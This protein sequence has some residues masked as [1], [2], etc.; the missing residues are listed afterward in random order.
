MNDVIIIGGGIA[1][2]SLTH[3]L[4]E[5]KINTILIEK[6]CIGG[7][8]KS[9]YFDKN[10]YCDLGPHILFL[11]KTNKK[12]VKNF[13]LQF[14]DLK[15]IKPYAK[16]YPTGKLTNPHDYPITQRNIQR[17]KNPSRMTL[18]VNKSPGEKTNSFEEYIINEIGQ[19]LYLKYFKNHTKKFWGYDPHLI[20]GNWYAKKI[21]FPKKETPFFGQLET[22]YPTC[23]Y[24][25]IIQNMVDDRSVI[26]DEVI[27]FVYKGNKILG[28]KTKKNGIINGKAFV[29]TINPSTFVDT[30]NLKLNY[31][32]IVIV[33]VLIELPPKTK[34]F[35]PYITWGYFPNHFSFTRIAEYSY[36]NPKTNNGRYLLTF[37]F[38]CFLKD[39]I[40]NKNDRWFR[41]YIESF[42]ED[43]KLSTKILQ[44]KIEKVEQAYPLPI[45]EEL[46]K[47]NIIKKQFNRYHNL[48]NLGRIGTYNYIWMKDIIIQAFEI[49]EK[50]VNR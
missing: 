30:L 8:L 28:V 33:A 35:E 24:S 39:S 4:K 16:T 15:I 45:F 46:E 6:H 38:P 23:K 18:N 9:I 22:Y 49:A 32:A 31:R 48:Y 3:L 27:G 47:Y 10:S 20:T 44:I 42:F 14:S 1:G 50:I 36:L 12:Q 34:L 26:H 13:F 17:W 41:K 37:E 2:C 11:D 19:N 40:W 25:E 5:K 7:L 43:Q 29:N 21:T